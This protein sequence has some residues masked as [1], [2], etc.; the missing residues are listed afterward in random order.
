MFEDVDDEVDMDF[1]P[2]FPK[3]IVVDFSLVTGMDSSAVDVL[4]DIQA[5][6]G[7]HDCK[8]F[9]SGMN[10]HFRQTVALGGVKPEI[11]ADRK[12]RKL[13]FF[14]DLDSAIGKAEDVVLGD[15]AFGEERCRE[16]R[17]KSGFRRALCFIDQQVRSASVIY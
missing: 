12:S 9:L 6:C 7:N 16:L 10:N 8:L 3:I 2:P 5:V 15:D 1:L 14:S 11:S 4:A 17:V 13:R